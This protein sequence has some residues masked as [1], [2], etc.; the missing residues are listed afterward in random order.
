MQSQQPTPQLEVHTWTSPVALLVR[1]LGRTTASRTWSCRRSSSTHASCG[2]KFGLAKHIP[3][4]CGEIQE[5]QDKRSGEN[6]GRWH[7]CEPGVRYADV[8]TAKKAGFA[9]F[10][11]S[12]RSCCSTGR[13]ESTKMPT[14]F[15]LV[16]FGWLAGLTEYRSR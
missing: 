6:E 2:L 10:V 15:V 11:N 7:H 5:H 12:E 9:A 16:G 1:T 13:K 8:T 14:L 4:N 3:L